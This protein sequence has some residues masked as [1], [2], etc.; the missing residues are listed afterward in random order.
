MNP[1]VSSVRAEH[2]ARL[3]LAS[4]PRLCPLF[5]SVNP[6]GQS[7]YTHLH[8]SLSRPTTSHRP[9]PPRP[10]QH[11][12]RPDDQPNHRASPRLRISFAPP[13][14]CRA[15]GRTGGWLRRVEG[16]A[17]A[18]RRARQERRRRDREGSPPSSRRGA[19]GPA[20]RGSISVP[21]GSQ[22]GP[23]REAICQNAPVVGCHRR[24]RCAT[25]NDPP[26]WRPSN[27][28]RSKNQ[29]LLA[30]ELPALT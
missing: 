27:M 2:A 24:T 14:P 4:A 13:T 19:S 18:Q 30:L 22:T 23:A 1:S 8:T 16:S 17:I 11:R 29:C 20:R 6:T 25:T 26:D 15:H 5:T 12:V 28:P 10:R 21:D 3:P 9:S 7:V